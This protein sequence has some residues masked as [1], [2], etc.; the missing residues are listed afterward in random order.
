MPKTIV[1]KIWKFPRISETFILNQAIVAIKLGYDVKLL[2]GEV[3]KLE[4]QAYKD[5]FEQHNIYDK[6]ILED[7]KM[8]ESRFFLWL[9]GVWLCMK[10]IG[11][12][13]SFLR[14]FKYSPKKDISLIYKFDFY[15]CF[16][17]VEIFHVQFGT[18]KD[19]VENLKKSGFLSCKLIVSFHGHDLY[20]PINNRIFNEAYYDNLFEVADHLISNT[21]FLKKKL[22]KLGAPASKLQNIPVSVDTNFF[23]VK[24]RNVNPEKITLVS[25]GRLV[26][27]KG[28]LWGIRSVALLKKQDYKIEYIIVGGGQL[29]EEL[30]K[31]AESLGLRDIVTFAGISN[32]FE[33]KKY[34]QQSDIFLMTS[35]TDPDYGVESQ[36]LVTAEAQACGSPVVAFD[37]GG[38]KYTLEENETGFICK[39]KDIN[40]FAEKVELLINDEKLRTKMGKNARKYV[41]H[42]F[43]ENAVLKAWKAIYA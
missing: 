7:Y 22:K 21:E 8:P 25:V 10:N 41:E 33:I 38:V 13:G 40:S 15:S 23:T 17:N 12:L 39:E 43:S 34:L 37:S 32:Q 18:N 29:R 16:R 11:C 27:F 36:G 20:F 6:I 35:V 31:E 4:S 9:K 14:Y 28:H 26:P 19:P 24:K 1:F 42:Y 5:V 3:E 30:E 2:V